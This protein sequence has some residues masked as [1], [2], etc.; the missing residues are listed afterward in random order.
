MRPWT[1]LTYLYCPS[2]QHLGEGA[3]GFPT[4]AIVGTGT[5]AVV[6]IIARFAPGQIM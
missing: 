1:M 6:Q 2:P 5:L 3:D 4:V